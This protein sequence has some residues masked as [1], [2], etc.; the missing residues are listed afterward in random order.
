MTEEQFFTSYVNDFS[1]KTLEKRISLANRLSD[2]GF[3]EEKDGQKYISCQALA[4]ARACAEEFLRLTEGWT[5]TDEDRANG[6][7]RFEGKTI[8][9]HD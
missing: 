1:E 7:A 6:F 9:L 2:E 3:W 8:K 5:I 4:D